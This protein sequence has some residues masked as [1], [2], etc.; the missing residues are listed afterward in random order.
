MGYFLR[1]GRPVKRS[2]WTWEGR[3]WYPPQSQAD[4]PGF[5]VVRDI[6]EY[7]T[8]TT[9]PGNDIASASHGPSGTEYGEPGEGVGDVRSD[10]SNDAYVDGSVAWVDQGSLKTYKSSRRGRVG[11]WTPANEVTD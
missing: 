5:V 7:N 6:L 9:T 4:N 1:F 2:P 10:G 8:V 11:M 3:A